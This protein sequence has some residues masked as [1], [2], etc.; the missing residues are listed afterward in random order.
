MSTLFAFLHHLAAF[1]LVSTLVLEFVL[2]K[3]DLSAA[4]ARRILITDAIY[5]MSAGLLIVVGL[6]RVFFFEKGAYYY[7]HSAPFVAKLVLFVF[8]GLLS[9]YPTRVFLSWRS[10]LKNNV[11]SGIS[12]DRLRRI[13][14]I[15][16]VELAGIVLILLCAA[17][18]A[19]GV[20]VVQP[21]TSAIPENDIYLAPRFRGETGMPMDVSWESGELKIDLTIAVSEY[22]LQT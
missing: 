7:L 3:Q 4:N 19:R 6:L 18:A 5:G 15:V 8:V 9:I 20:G 12:A 13:R 10:Q 22:Y 14:L 11:F 2:L 16:H 17:M 21:T 1:A